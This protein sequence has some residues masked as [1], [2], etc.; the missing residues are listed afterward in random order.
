MEHRIKRACAQLVSMALQFFDHAETKDWF[1]RGVI[2]NVDA[3]QAREKPLILCIFG[4]SQ[5]HQQL[6]NINIEM[7]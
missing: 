2:E 1:F 4:L 7:R 6:S 3:D 5:F